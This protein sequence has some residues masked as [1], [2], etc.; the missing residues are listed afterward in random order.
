[1][2]QL[3]AYLRLVPEIAAQIYFP[4]SHSIFSGFKLRATLAVC[5]M[6]VAITASFAWGVP[7][8]DTRTSATGLVTGIFAKS[9]GS[10]F[11]ET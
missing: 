6:L 1:M 3:S 2:L 7:G 11:P 10:S 9:L 4:P 5:G 8:T